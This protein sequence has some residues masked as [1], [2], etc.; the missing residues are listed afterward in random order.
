[1]SQLVHIK[2]LTFRWASQKPVILDIEEMSIAEGERVFLKGPSGSGKTS[3]LSLIGGIS[4]PTQGE[5][6]ILDQSINQMK[7]SMRDQFRSDH[8]G[9]I[10]Q[11]FNLLPYLSVVENVTLSC[12]FSP[13]RKTKVVGRGTS[14]EAEAKRLLDQLSFPSE[15]VNTR[16]NEL[17]VGQQQRVAVARALI[18][19]PELIIA[20][21]PSS[22]LDAETR[23]DFIRLLLNE[24]EAA[25]SSILFV[26]HDPALESY[27]DRT[28][29][30]DEINRAASAQRVGA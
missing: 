24:C 11:Q 23:G 18:G 20:D 28:L 14:L 5:I 3:L 25:G 15:L 17:S 29:H 30:L 6:A 27:F 16:V 7:Q 4:S 10:F 8:I 13:S 12:R 22:A 9:F 26:S 19:A 1:M 2:E 21:E